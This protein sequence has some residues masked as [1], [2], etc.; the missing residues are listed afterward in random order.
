MGLLPG[1]AAEAAGGRLAALQEPNDVRSELCRRGGRR[2]ARGE[3][4]G[5]LT[6]L[7]GRAEPSPLAAQPTHTTRH[8]AFV[9][10]SAMRPDLLGRAGRAGRGCGRSSRQSTAARRRELRR[11]GRGG[12]HP[13]RAGECAHGDCLVR[14]CTWKVRPRQSWPLAD[15]GA[16]RRALSRRLGTAA[17]NTPV[18]VPGRLRRP[19]RQ[20]PSCSSLRRTIFL[21]R[22]AC[23]RAK[24][25]GSVSGVC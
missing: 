18:M 12:S 7:S 9:R 17:S 5:R 14:R 6:G 10:G 15:E 19:L 23:G 4:S 16:P 8:S 13:S 22:S 2:E 20:Y 24:E 3:I 1:P 21:R 11:G 25:K